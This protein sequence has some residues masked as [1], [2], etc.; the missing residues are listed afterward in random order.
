MTAKN[1]AIVKGRVRTPEQ[2]AGDAKRRATNAGRK[3]W[4]RAMSDAEWD[5]RFQKFVDPNYYEAED[6]IRGLIGSTLGSVYSL[7]RSGRTG[8]KPTN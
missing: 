4:K 6:R 8:P 5:R 3:T 7:N 2:R 1:L